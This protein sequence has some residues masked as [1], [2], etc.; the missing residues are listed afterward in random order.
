MS[1]QYGNSGEAGW[2]CI[3][4]CLILVI[5]IVIGFNSYTATTWNDGVC[6]KCKIRYEL[7]GVS[8]G[9]K[10]YSCPACGLEVS[11]YLS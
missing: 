8:E 10:Y 5:A 2:V 1:S 11:R 7:M 3:L 9:L 4:V 6:P